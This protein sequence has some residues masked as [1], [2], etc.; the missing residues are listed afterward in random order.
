MNLIKGIRIAT[1]RKG[2]AM[3][4]IWSVKNR[5]KIPT[6]KQKKEIFNAILMV[7]PPPRFEK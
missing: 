2:I 6:T 3:G 5:V 7:L 1:A 4:Q